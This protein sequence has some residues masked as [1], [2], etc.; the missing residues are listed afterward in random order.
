D[1]YNQ[2]APPQGQYDVAAHRRTGH[3]NQE[4]G[5]SNNGHI[6]GIDDMLHAMKEIQAILKSELNEIRTKDTLNDDTNEQESQS[7]NK[8]RLIKTRS[9][10]KRKLSRY[11]IS[12]YIA[13]PVYASIK[14]RYGPFR[15]GIA[16]NTYDEQ[17]ITYILSKT[18]PTYEVV[19]DINHLCVTRKSFR[20]LEPSKF[21]DSEVT[22]PITSLNSYSMIFKHPKGHNFSW[23]LPKNYAYTVL[24]CTDENQLLLKKSLSR[25]WESY[26]YDLLWCKKVTHECPIILCR[27]L[28]NGVNTVYFI[29]STCN[30]VFFHILYYI[31][32]NDLRNHW[33]LA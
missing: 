1:I 16:L 4:P 30:E 31:P 2:P 20:T 5:T 3:A 15:I 10:V 12:P 28:F 27:H 24:T 23:F 22:L 21:V 17:L 33:Y 18:L 26:M 14:Y 8:R 32:I 11:Q 7:T 6:K 19:V 9:T 29:M 25:M 13:G